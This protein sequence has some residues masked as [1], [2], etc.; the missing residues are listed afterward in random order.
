MNCNICGKPVVLVPSARER[1]EKYGGSPD[2][3]TKL[4]TSHADCF[5][6][7][8]RKDTAELMRRLNK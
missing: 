3:Y 4:F 7:K 8:R 5:I 1:A 6:E 2:D